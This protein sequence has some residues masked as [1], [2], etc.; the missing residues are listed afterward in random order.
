LSAAAGNL[1]LDD[2]GDLAIING[3][4]AISSGSGAVLQAVRSRLG[5]FQ[6]EWF[7]D[8]SVGIPYWQQILGIKN[9]PLPAIR[10]IFR[11][12]IATTPGI[13]SVTSIDL[14]YTGSRELTLT[15]TA[16]MDDGATTVTDSLQ[17]EV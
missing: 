7:L 10:E 16:K 9:P 3:N 13:A 1:L 4:L 2:D 8:E 11:K 12:E 6:G 14:R 5:F 17:L 15:W